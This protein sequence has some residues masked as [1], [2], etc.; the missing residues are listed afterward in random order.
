MPV[1]AALKARLD[2][3][4]KQGWERQFTTE[5]PRLSE[6]VGL[7]ESLG[8]EVRLE[9]A[10]SDLPLPE[11]ATCYESFCEKYK[12]IFIRRIQDPSPSDLF[13]N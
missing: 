5:E 11:C 2:E 8:Y 9:P 7:Y 3:L 4:E 13:D 6:A 1:P 12:T 10:C